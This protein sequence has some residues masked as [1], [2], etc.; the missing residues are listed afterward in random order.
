MHHNSF[1]LDVRSKEFV[2]YSSV[3]EL[4]EFIKTKDP[5]EQLLHIGG[6][7]NLLFTKDFD[8]TIL[9]SAIKG[10]DVKEDTAESVLL[11][12]GAA[13]I[14]DEVV[15]YT[16]SKGYY[17]L[18]NLSLIPSEVGAA[19]VQ[20]IG[21]YGAEAK[22]FIEEVEVVELATGKV[23][24]FSNADCHFAYRYSNFKGPWKGLYAVTHVT[25]RLN[26]TFVPNLTY[27][28]LAQICTPGM[29][30][31]AL[32]EA[33]IQVRQNKLP[34][35]KE[36]GNA[37]SFFMNPVVSKEVY[38]KVAQDYPS[39]PHYGAEGGVKIPAGWLIEQCGWKGRALGRAAVYEK[40]ALVLVNLGHAQP[41]DIMNLSDQVCKDVKEKFGIEIHPEVNWI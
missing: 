5:R 30:A 21:A 15:A 24:R 31:Q 37:G 17:G 23:Q 36:I 11:R 3:A 25:L 10:T 22:D 19:A 38:E 8:G 1:G 26:K 20:N 39:V 33:I 12:V 27:G 14:W 34:D 16:I 9:H 29:D 18:E 7:N 35:P 13:E 40:Q 2:E 6:G 4:Q 28:A 41:E 32:R